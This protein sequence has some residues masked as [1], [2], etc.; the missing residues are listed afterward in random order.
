VLLHG[1]QAA[2]GAVLRSPAGQTFVIAKPGRQP[3]LKALVVQLSSAKETEVQ[4]AGAQPGH[5]TISP[6]TAGPTLSAVD[7]SSDLG[8][9]VINATVSGQGSSRTLRY[10]LR[11]LPA[12]ATIAFVENGSGGGGLIGR[13][14]GTSGTLRF[15]PSTARTGVRTIVAQVTAPDGTPRATLTVARYSAATPRPGRASRLRVRHIGTKLVI[16]FTP[17]ARA[18]KQAVSVRLSDGR[19]LLFNVGGHVRSVTVKAVT[20][21]VHAL[22]IVVR[23]SIGGIQGPALRGR[24]G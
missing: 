24:G 3:A 16:T 17:A 6:A 2:P 22:S 12:G 4:I 15:T 21:S 14:T 1:N 10:T 13:S 5:W 19:G 18:T 23:G 8:K 9:P 20:R 11:N 7:V